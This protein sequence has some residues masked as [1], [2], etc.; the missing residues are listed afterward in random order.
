[1]NH[2]EQTNGTLACVERGDGAGRGDWGTEGR[3]GEGEEKEE[4][5]KEKVEGRRDGG[6]CGG[7]ARWRKQV[8]SGG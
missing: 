2:L 8:G 3:R 1:M 4:R 5:V 6:S 7:N